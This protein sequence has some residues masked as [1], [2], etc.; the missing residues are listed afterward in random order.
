[1]PYN[2]GMTFEAFARLVPESLLDCPGEVFYSGRAAF[3][4]SRP[5]YLLGYNPG[6][7]PGGSRS[8]VRS[9]IE[10]ACS[11]KDDR[12]S[13]YYQDWGPGRR[14]DMQRSV[15]HFFLDSG[16]CAELTPSSNCVFIRSPNVPAISAAKRR[17]FEVA[18]WSFHK[19]VIEQLGVKAILCMGGAA[20]KSVHRRFRDSSLICEQ[21]WSATQAHRAY[22]TACGMVLCQLVH[23]SYGHWQCPKYNPAPLVRRVLELHT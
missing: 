23:P 6:S 22:R 19:E 8:T 13:L 12:F 3:S 20:Y 9:S 11:R 10:V 5:V 7:D 2:R 15:K 18:C 4:G 17:Q 16:L 14:K 21:P 1:M